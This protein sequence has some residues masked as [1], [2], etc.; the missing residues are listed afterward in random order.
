MKSI[1]EGGDGGEASEEPVEPM[2]EGQAPTYSVIDIQTK[3]AVGTFRDGVGFMPGPNAAKLGYKPG[4]TAPN[5][6][7]VDYKQQVS[8]QGVAKGDYPDGSSIRTPGADE[9]K[10]QYQQAV[11]AVKNAKTHQEYEAASDRTGRIKDLLAS[12]GIQVG[13]VLGEQGVVS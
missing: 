1:S 2:S 11:M 10:Q 12:K 3:K 13:P 9:W 7:K 6:T 5:G 4:P 8:E